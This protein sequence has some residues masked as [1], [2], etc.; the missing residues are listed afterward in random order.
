[1]RAVIDLGQWVVLSA[2]TASLMFVLVCSLAWRWWRTVWGRTS[3]AISGALSVALLPGVLNVLLG[4]NTGTLWF[5]W[6]RVASIAVVFAIEVWR[7]V[8]VVRA[9]WRRVPSDGEP[10]G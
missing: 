1:M 5:A 7:T 3:V 4:V 10:E 6:Y 9:Q 2:F 8:A